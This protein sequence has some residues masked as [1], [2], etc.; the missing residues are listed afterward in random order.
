MSCAASAKIFSNHRFMSIL[1]AMILI[2]V[3]MFAQTDAK[4]PQGNPG[5]QEGFNR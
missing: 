4:T 3:C 2:S 5:K 1:I